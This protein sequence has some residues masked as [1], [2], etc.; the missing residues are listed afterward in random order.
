MQLKFDPVTEHSI[1]TT[2]KLKSRIEVLN[3]QTALEDYSISLLSHD[4]LMTFFKEHPRLRYGRLFLLENG[5]LRAT[6]RD[7]NGNHI[8]LEFFDSQT[9]GFVIFGQ[10]S[11]NLPNSRLSGF[12]SMGGIDK[13]IGVYEFG[14]LLFV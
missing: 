4:A 7:E 5:N 6:W 8:A 2:I 13:L 3:E 9:V 12:D 10:L 11:Q 14:D 1:N